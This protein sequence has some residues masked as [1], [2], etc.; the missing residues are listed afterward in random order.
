[1]GVITLTGGFLRQ[2]YEEIVRRIQ[3]KE[4]KVQRINPLE[5]ILSLKK[6]SDG[7]TVETLTDNLAVRIGRLCTSYSKEASI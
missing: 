4:K 3:N 2:H 6:K 7:L 5:R 1:M